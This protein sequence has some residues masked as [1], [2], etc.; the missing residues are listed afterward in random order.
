MKRLVLS[1]IAASML[2]ASAVSGQAAPLNAPVAPQSAI[3][4]VDWKK[5]SGHEVKKPADHNWK[6]PANR[7]VKK[8]VIV[9]KKVVQHPSWKRGQRYSDWRHQP[10]VN[11]WQ[12]YHL[13]RPGIGQQWVHVGNDYLLVSILTGVIAG[14]VAAH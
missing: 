8:Q 13:R 1:A 2:A 11:D 14:V 9:K 6:K 4:Q 5:P 7:E 10:R 12:R 3:L